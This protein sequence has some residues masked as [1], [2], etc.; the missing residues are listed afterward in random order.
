MN[1]QLI[2]QLR[3]MSL[4]RLGANP[5]DIRDFFGAAAFRDHL[6]DLP[7]PERELAKLHDSGRSFP[8]INADPAHADDYSLGISNRKFTHEN[9]T[10]L[11]PDCVKLNCLQYLT[12]FDD[13]LIV[14]AELRG[15]VNGPDVVI[16]FSPPSL[17]VR[18]YFC[19]GL[20]NVNVASIPI[21]HPRKT[22]EMIHKRHQAN[23]WNWN[24]FL[25]SLR[26][27]H[28]A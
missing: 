15:H 16:R 25:A 21:F 28:V 18:G 11:A 6:Q 20:V 5:Q 12:G 14:K 22:G 24:P 26:L 19:H 27:W 23:V 4:D 7:F 1:V 8:D 2:H 3:T 17:F 10:R 9:V 13:L